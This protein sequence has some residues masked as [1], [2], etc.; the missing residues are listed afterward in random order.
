MRFASG[1]ILLKTL[2]E[3]KNGV[4]SLL[5]EKPGRFVDSKTPIWHK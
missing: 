3:L 5:S 4:E 1:L 2:N